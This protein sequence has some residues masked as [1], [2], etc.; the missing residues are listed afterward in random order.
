[1]LTPMLASGLCED[2]RRENRLMGKF[3]AKRTANF[4]DYPLSFLTLTIEILFFLNFIKAC[5]KNSEKD[6]KTTN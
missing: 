2:R 4:F 3:I 6:Q 5:I 1:M